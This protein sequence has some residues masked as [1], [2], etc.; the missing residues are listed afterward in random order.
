MVSLICGF[1]EKLKSRI[2]RTD[3][4]LPEARGGGLGKVSEGGQKVQTQEKYVL[5]RSVQPGDYSHALPNVFSDN[6]DHTCDAVQ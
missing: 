5:R 6:N 4:W 3:W 2:P 1:S